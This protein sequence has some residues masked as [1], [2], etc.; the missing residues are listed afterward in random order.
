MKKYCHQMTSA[1]GGENKGSD[2]MLQ[3]EEES[4]ESER[5]SS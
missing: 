2:E 5:G 3:K 1:E 4:N